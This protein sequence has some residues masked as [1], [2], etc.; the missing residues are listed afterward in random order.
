MSIAM[1]DDHL[2]DRVARELA[3][4]EPTWHFGLTLLVGTLV[5]SP[6][7]SAAVTGRWAVPTAL[8]VYAVTLVATW[9]SVGLVAGAF[10]LVG[11]SPADRLAGDDVDESTGGAEGSTPERLES[12][13][14]DGAH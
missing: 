11:P 1:R 6:V 9:L 7:L 13:G 12:V 10:A 5:A 14:S 4:P 3:S 2:A 8:A